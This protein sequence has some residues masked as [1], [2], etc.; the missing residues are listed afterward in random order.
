M[1]KVLC[2]PSELAD[3][4]AFLIQDPTRD[5]QLDRLQIVLNDFVVASKEGYVSWVGHH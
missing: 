5:H 4:L 2:E 1:T 3:T